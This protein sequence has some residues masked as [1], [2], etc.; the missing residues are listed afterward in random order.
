FGNGVVTWNLGGLA[1]NAT[2]P[3]T[4]AVQVN[5]PAAAGVNSITNPA[6][7]ADD[8]ANGPD[9]NPNDNQTSDMDTLNAAPDLTITKDDGLTT[10][11]PGQMVT[12][13]LTISNVGNQGATG[14]VVMDTL[15]A[16]TTFVS[17]TGSFSVS[18][19]VA[20]FNIGALGGGQS[21]T[22][23]LVVQVNTPVP[24]GVTE[25]VNPATI[26]DDG[27]NGT[28][29]PP[30]INSVPARRA[31]DLAPDLTITKDDGLTTVTPGQM[32]TYTLTITNA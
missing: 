25:I 6:Q 1:V 8:G 5:N 27:A 14:V 13:T 20:T 15:P 10:V 7:V 22:R 3:L 2:V 31:S 23:T 12:Y 26:T 4:L 9:L 11:T 29:P 17:A 28:D 19:G 30:D 21:G 18:N 24:A 32:V 16:N